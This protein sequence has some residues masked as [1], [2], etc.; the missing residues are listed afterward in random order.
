[1]DHVQKVNDTRLITTTVHEYLYIT[2]SNNETGD[3]CNRT[4]NTTIETS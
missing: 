3:G 2:F 1:M 4:M